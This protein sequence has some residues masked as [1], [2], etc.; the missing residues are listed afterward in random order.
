[1]RYLNMRLITLFCLFSMHVFSQTVYL[2]T[3]DAKCNCIDTKTIV[4]NNTKLIKH[5]KA[6][7]CGGNNGIKASSKNNH[8]AFEKEHSTNWY[9]VIFKVDGNFCFTLKPFKK[10]DDYD[11]M[12]Y[13]SIPDF[14]DSLKAGKV[15]ALRANISR[16]KEDIEGYTGMNS[17]SKKEFVKQGVGDAYCKSL[18]VKKGEEYYLILDN[19]YKNGQGFDLEIFFETQV[20][21]NGQVVD[22]E[23][24]PIKAEV[25]INNSRGNQVAKVFSDSLTGNYKFNLSLKDNQQFTLN[26]YKDN[27]FFYTRTFKSNDTTLL[28]PINQ[29]L[30]KLKK[31]SK[32]SV[33][34]INFDPDADTYILVSVPAIKN[35]LKLMQKNTDLNITIVGHTNGCGQSGYKGGV[36][37]L[38]EGRA[39]K[40]KNYLTENKIEAKRITTLG[41]DCQEMIYPD[42]GPFWQQE[43]NRR[44]EIMV[45]E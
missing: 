21:I 4:V 24:K 14:C 34:T 6:P 16:D 5:N 23:N 44:V 25:T 19:V 36:K 31:G 17:T 1:M 41:K 45:K 29:I 37:G 32:Y 8:F 42:D 27:S 10:D 9:K 43:A 22:E 15:K 3:T 26:Y 40:I 18:A 33:G 11:F 12:L 39:K 30:P 35:L 13:K 20:N 7:N 38:S 2:D 28:K